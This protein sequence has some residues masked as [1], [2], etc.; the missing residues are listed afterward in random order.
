MDLNINID[1]LRVNPDSSSV[2][3]IDENLCVSKSLDVLNAGLSALSGLTTSAKTQID[4]WSQLYTQ[5][6]ISSADWIKNFSWYT[7]FKSS[8]NQTYKTVQTLSATAWNR[9][10]ISV[11]CPTFQ[12]LS[13]WTANSTAIHQ[14]IIT[15]WLNGYFPST[16]YLEGQQMRV[17]F[18]CYQ[19]VRYQVN[20]AATYYDTCNRYPMTPVGYEGCYNRY[21]THIYPPTDPFF[22][23]KC[24]GEPPTQ[25]NCTF[26]SSVVDDQVWPWIMSAI[27]PFKNI[28]LGW[29]NPV[30]EINC[31]PYDNKLLSI[32]YSNNNS[33]EPLFWNF[34]IEKPIT[35][36]KHFTVTNT[37]N[38]WIL[39]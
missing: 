11:L 34:Y 15:G 13:A 35:T 24:H 6:Q 25:P 2:L 9:K 38:N 27:C 3:L 20:Y 14:Q 23:G 5:F 28:G 22:T 8:W 19:D 4:T 21:V 32:S 33:A 7:K 39:S 26:R 10:T 17:T 30:A 1:S 29:D 18:W 31:K 37:S 12:S 16:Q 36:V